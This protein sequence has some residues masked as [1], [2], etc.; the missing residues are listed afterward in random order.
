[1]MLELLTYIQLSSK[2][3]SDNF[4]HA[5]VDEKAHRLYV[6]HPRTNQIDVIDTKEDKP[7]RSLSGFPGAAGVVFLREKNLILVTN[8][9]EDALATFSTSTP[10]KIAKFKTGGGPDGVAYEATESVALVGNKKDSSLS[11]V[12]LKNKKRTY[13]ISLPGKP[14]WMVYDSVHA[15]FFVNVIDPPQIAV[16]KV[17]ATYKL[18]KPTVI[19]SVGPHGLDVDENSGTL[20]CATDGKILFFI[21]TESGLIKNKI[22]I[23]GSPDVIFYNEKLHHLYIAIKDPGVIDVIDTQKAKRAAVIPTEK[24]AHT[25]VF[26]GP[27][28]KVYSFLPESH[29]IM[30][31]KDTGGN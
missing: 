11:V 14:R 20:F 1:M 21:D 24:G 17:G 8:E 28:N 22:E 30:V 26:D 31:F 25:L 3:D 16:V 4:D 12:D 27:L 29:R 7:L 9:N 2:V 6:A 23:S 18:E 13:E 10:D 19:P 15:K 5:T